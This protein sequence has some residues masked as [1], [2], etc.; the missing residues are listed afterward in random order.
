MLKK[1]LLVFG[2]AMVVG[3]VAQADIYDDYKLLAQGIITNHEKIVALEKE[4]AKLKPKTTVVNKTSYLHDELS[5]QTI[6]KLKKMSQKL[7]ADGVQYDNNGTDGNHV[8]AM[9]ANN[10]K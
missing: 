5:E 4:V 3:S 2:V 10:T 7:S 9:D 1:S 6:A 8:K